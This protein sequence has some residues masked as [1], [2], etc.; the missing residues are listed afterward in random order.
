MFT[1]LT[2]ETVKNSSRL[3]SLSVFPSAKGTA[4]D[5]V[6]WSFGHGRSRAAL[7][8]IRRYAGSFNFQ[9]AARTIALD[10]L[11][12]H[13][14]PRAAARSLQGTKRAGAVSFVPWE[15]FS[16]ETSGSSNRDRQACGHAAQNRGQGRRER[17]KI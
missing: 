16:G 17:V 6:A 4:C 3:F 10:S 15:D 1:I 12:R 8:G 5:D 9:F 2:N 7:S 14:L 13:C 11:V